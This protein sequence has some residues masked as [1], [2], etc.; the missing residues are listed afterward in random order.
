MAR[1]KHGLGG[2]QEF[3]VSHDDVV[4]SLWRTWSTCRGEAVPPSSA[5]AT[6]IA[7]GD[8]RGMW[9]TASADPPM[10]LRALLRPV[11]PDAACPGDAEYARLA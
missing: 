1:V 9:P 5:V 8:L 7:A 2:G 6:A 11:G 3:E 10:L 4:R